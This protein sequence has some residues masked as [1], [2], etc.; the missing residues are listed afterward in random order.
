MATF[1]LF[2][3][4][5]LKIS[6]VMVVAVAIGV[7]GTMAIGPPPQFFAQDQDHYD[8]SL[9]V[10]CTARVQST[11]RGCLKLIPGST[12]RASDICG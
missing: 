8:G 2:A 11:N 3:M 10:R 5:R 9:M 12:E 7:A 4:A 1:Q 6:N